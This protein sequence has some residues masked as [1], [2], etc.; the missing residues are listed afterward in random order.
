M[1]VIPYMGLIL[2]IVPALLLAF[3]A[4]GDWLHPLLVVV[5]FVVAQLLEGNLITP[6]IVGEKVGMHPV[7]VIVSLLVFGE[8][9]GF[10]GL[11]LAVPVTAVGMVFLRD[12]VE[13]YK[14]GAAPR[15]DETPSGT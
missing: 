4:H 5:V 3:S 10:V 8:L 15:A 6:R 13:K 9:F 12:A 11:L 2:G 1:S 7:T 14:A